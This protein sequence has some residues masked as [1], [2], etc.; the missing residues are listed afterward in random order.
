MRQALK[1]AARGLGRVEPNPTVGAVIVD[2]DDRVI[3][4]GWHERFGGP[5]AEI[6]AIDDARRHD[7]PLAG[8]TMYVSLEPCCHHGKTGPCTDAIIAAG[9]T[10]VF[11]AMED[12]DPN[13]AGQGLAQLRAAGV[14]VVAGLCEEEAHSQLAAYS[15]LRRQGRP[16]LI[17]KWAQ[18]SDGFLYVPADAG[19]WVTGT[20][21]RNH[22]H[23]V[24]AYVDG[25]AVGVGTLVEDDPMLTNRSGTGKQPARVVLDA[26][27]RTPPDC[28]MART[29]QIAPMIVATTARAVASADPEVLDLFARQDVELLQLPE[30]QAGIDAEALLD[31]LGRR[32]WT[33]LMVEGGARVHENLLTAGLADELLVYISPVRLGS[34][35]EAGPYLN[36]DDWADRIDLPT[37]ETSHLGQDELRR[38]VL[39]M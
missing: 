2:E 20:E 27:L 8:A 33:Y 39:H 12:P 10:R 34:Q 17:C 25:I 3:G 38:Y 19:R 5:H 35:E 18:T 15:K 11:A 13:V 32:Q 22:V 29:T 7:E 4:R 21:A 6:A 14:E 37:P 26:N 1:L 30:A 23:Q 24:R 9:I 36:I 16:W 28:Q 31:E